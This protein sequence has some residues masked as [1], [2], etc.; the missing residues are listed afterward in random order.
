MPGCRGGKIISGTQVSNFHR[1]WLKFLQELD[2]WR[3]GL[4]MLVLFL[5]ALRRCAHCAAQTC[6]FKKNP[7]IMKENYS[8]SQKNPTHLVAVT[9]SCVRSCLNYSLGL[10]VWAVLHFKQEAEE[11][12]WARNL[13]VFEFRYTREWQNLGTCSERNNFPTAYEHHLAHCSWT[14]VSTKDLNWWKVFHLLGK[15]EL[16]FISNLHFT[17]CDF[18][19]YCPFY[20]YFS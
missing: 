15:V 6:A 4:Y 11:F 14:R 10:K 18:E 13:L 3:S 1:K 5:G 2:S 7:R 9:F 16:Y 12:L 8:Y 20:A 17:N 19:L